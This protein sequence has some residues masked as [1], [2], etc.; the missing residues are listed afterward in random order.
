[1]V[2]KQLRI[3]SRTLTFNPQLFYFEVFF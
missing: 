2:K 3:E 1:M